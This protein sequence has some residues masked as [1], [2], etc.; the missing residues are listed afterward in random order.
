M[1]PENVEHPWSPQAEA[2]W[3]EIAKQRSCKI[4]GVEDPPVMSLD[5]VCEECLHEQGRAMCCLE[6]DCGARTE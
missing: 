6:G 5:G 1:T 3:K 4:C 2:V